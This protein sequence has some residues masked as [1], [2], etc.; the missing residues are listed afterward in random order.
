MNP[1]LISPGSKPLTEPEKAALLTLL[2]DDDP[3][4]IEGVRARILS[5]GADVVHWLTPHRLS[6]QPSLRRHVREI[7]THFARLEADT[8]FLAFCLT[9]GDDLDLEEGVLLLAATR[10]PEL[11]PAAY[12]ALLDQYAAEIAERAN[13]LG[14][15]VEMLEVVNRMLF[16]EL[17][18]RGNREAYYALENNYFNRVLDR[19]MGNPINLCVLYWLVAR[20][21][22]LP[23]VGIGMPSHFLCR[24][25]TSTDS[26]FVDAFN[27]GRLLTR[28]HCVAYLQSS[29]YGFQESFLAPVT[30]RETLLRMCGNIHQ[31]HARQ[32]QSEQV[33]QFQRYLIALSKRHV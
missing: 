32:R 19:R 33:A 24:Y 15:G 25:Q 30:T 14:R 1:S 16:R 21:L 31:Y 27:Q 3:V 23:V 5:L 17:G 29:G 2:A 13:G 26:F 10:Y 9:H 6:E 28:A 7:L 18:F 4:V 11:N 22:Q 20:R 12:R 8:R